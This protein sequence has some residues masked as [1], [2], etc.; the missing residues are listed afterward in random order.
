V[1][2]EAELKIVPISRGRDT[3]RILAA[4]KTPVVMLLHMAVARDKRPLRCLAP[5]AAA[6]AASG[7]SNA[8]QGQ[9]RWLLERRL[10]K[11]RAM[12]S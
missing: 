7:I 9:L 11:R 4:V 10:R 12:P 6:A 8:E 3:C 2:E 1:Q 5:L